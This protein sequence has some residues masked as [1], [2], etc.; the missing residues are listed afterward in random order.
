MILSNSKD[1]NPLLL[2][3]CATAG[4]NIEVFRTAKNN[5][6]ATQPS[7]QTASKSS[8]GRTTLS[9][10]VPRPTGDTGSSLNSGAQGGDSILT[11]SAPDGTSPKTGSQPQTTGVLS[12]RAIVALS[13]VGGVVLIVMAFVG[14]CCWCGYKKKVKKRLRPDAGPDKVDIAETVITNWRRD[15]AELTPQTSQEAIEMARRPSAPLLPPRQNI[16][17]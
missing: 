16:A 15:V 6:D 8:I 17:V 9:P 13:I 14:T 2:P 12:T 11:G 5:A 7:T 10:N 4:G 3:H 1:L